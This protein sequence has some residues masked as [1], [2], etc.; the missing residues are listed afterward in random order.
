[1]VNENRP[2]L[3]DFTQ[4]TLTQVNALLAQ[5]QQFVAGLSRLTSEIEQNPTRFLLGDRRDGYRP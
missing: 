5:T 2:G 4:R 1:M 3:R